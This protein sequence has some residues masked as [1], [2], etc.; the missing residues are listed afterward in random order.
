MMMMMMV[1][2]SL[3]HSISKELQFH[4]KRTVVQTNIDNNNEKLNIFIQE[5]ENYSFRRRRRCLMF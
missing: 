1:I 4:F 5:I 3:G 2:L